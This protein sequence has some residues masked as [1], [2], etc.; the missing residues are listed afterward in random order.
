MG[1]KAENVFWGLRVGLVTLALGLTWHR[2]WVS[3]GGCRDAGR[4][5]SAFGS[6]MVPEAVLRRALLNNTVGL[7]P[8]FCDLT[9][10]DLIPHTQ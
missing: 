6:R 5:G 9:A 7:R 1:I 10:A 3:C 4:M 8:G 2:K